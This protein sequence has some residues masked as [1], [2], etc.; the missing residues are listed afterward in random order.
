MKTIEIT[1]KQEFKL[2]S[3]IKFDFPYSLFSLHLFDNVKSDSNDPAAA[4]T[5]Y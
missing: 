5:D 1:S 4:P 3:Q 2:E